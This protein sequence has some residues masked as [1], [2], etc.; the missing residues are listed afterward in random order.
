M[1]Y[2]IQCHDGLFA[3]YYTFQGDQYIAVEQKGRVKPKVYSSRKRAENI[4]EKV[5]QLTDWQ[6]NF[7][8]YIVEIEDRYFDE[9]ITNNE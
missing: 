9:R 7:N 3:G 5:R 6:I 1:K 4:L 2:V 8:P